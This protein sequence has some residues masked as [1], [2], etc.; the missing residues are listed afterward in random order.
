[1]ASL[2][3]FVSVHAGYIFLSGGL[4]PKNGIGIS[5]LG[6]ILDVCTHTHNKHRDTMPKSEVL[7]SMQEDWLLRFHP[8]ACLIGS[9]D[10]LGLGLLLVAPRQGTR[11]TQ[12][13]GRKTAHKT[14]ATDELGT[15]SSCSGW[16]Q[17]ISGMAAV[18]SQLGPAEYQVGRSR[19]EPTGVQGWLVGQ[20]NAVYINRKEGK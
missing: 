10:S 18:V 9:W 11:F 14:T 16:L 13:K 2:W 15:R 12:T 19:S 6:G 8:G 7:S 17:L 1:M 3:V 4:G 5:V 20:H